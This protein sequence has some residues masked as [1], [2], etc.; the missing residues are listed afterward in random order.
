MS[1]TYLGSNSL[2]DPEIPASLITSGTLDDARIPSGITRDSEL[3]DVLV[4]FAPI[5][6]PIILDLLTVNQSTVGSAVEKLVSVATNDDV[7]EAVYQGRVTTTDAS[8]TT[9]NSV[10]IVAGT[11]TIIITTI[12]ARRTGGSAGA[13]DDGAG[14]H[15]M[16]VFKNVGGTVTQIGSTTIMGSA[17][18]QAGW[19]ATH[20]TTTN[21]VT[22]RVFGAVNNN[23]VWHATSRAYSVST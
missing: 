22:V 14:Y 19:N 4:D 5:T 23:V 10:P 1:K 16:S 7:T 17:E 6:N 21:G 20:G 12:V 2:D 8:G 9:V 18:S 13:A 11:T 3:T 15:F